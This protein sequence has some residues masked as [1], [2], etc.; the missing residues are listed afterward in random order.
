[1]TRIEQLY[2][3]FEAC[4]KQLADCY[5]L[6]HERFIANPRLAKFWA[7]SAMAQLEH[8]SIVRFCREKGLMA[9]MD[10]GFEATN[11]IEQLLEETKRIA[12]KP[13]VTI[14]DAFYASL[15]MESSEI[16]EVYEKLTRPLVK[17]HSRLYAVVVASLR[18]HHD[19]FADGARAFCADDTFAAAF[20]MLGRSERRTLARS[21]S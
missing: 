17:D 6:L 15:L 14:E 12:R 18:T 21:T 2:T 8:S 19:R 7:D 16:D 13:E 4:E 5:F 3:R 1:M 9:E 11:H 20:Q 10:L